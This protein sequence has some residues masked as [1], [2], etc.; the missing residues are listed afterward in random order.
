MQREEERA[1]ALSP[2][3]LDRP[4][5]KQVRE[6]ALPVHLGLVFVQVVVAR[7][8]AVSEVIHAARERAEELLVAALQWPEVGR[9]A[10]MPL[11]H[12]RGGI[13]CVAQ[14]RGQGRVRRQQAQN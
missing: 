7:G 9:V 2:D 14:E 5:G 6:I 1:L 3:E 13:A 4:V 8:V 10:E 12:E 11:A